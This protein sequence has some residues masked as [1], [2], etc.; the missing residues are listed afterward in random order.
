MDLSKLKNGQKI[1]LAA[2][3]VM[4]IN[5]FLPWYRVSAFGFSASI[6][7]FDSEFWAWFGSLCAIAAAVIIALK[8]FANMK[9]NAGPLK[10]EH[11]ALI[12]GGLGF[13]FI[14][15]RLLTETTSMFIGLWIGLIVSAVLAYG[16]FMAMKEEGLSIQD[17][18]SLGGGSNPP[19]PPPPA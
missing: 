15:I 9:I 12:L 10:A 4:I 14:L 8:V 13:L 11:L 17:F 3:I 2:G 1:V 19:P 7:A 16:A 18:K 5:L 6:N